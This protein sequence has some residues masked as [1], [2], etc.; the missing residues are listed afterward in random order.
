MAHLLWHASKPRD[1]LLGRIPGHEGLY[2]V[3]RHPD[4]VQIPGLVVYLPQ[5]SLVFFNAEYIMR[6][7]L[8]NARRLRDPGAWLILD[9]SAMNEMDSTGVAAL[10]DARAELVRRGLRFGI[11]DLH[12]R[13][14]AIIERSGLARRIGI[15]MLF[16]S[17]EQAAAAFD[18]QSHAESAHR[19]AWPVGS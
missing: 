8:K 9:A 11:A 5:S 1:A 14:R 10:E 12:S 3:H 17:A 15:D 6:R 4:A 2:K 18:A 16:E 13:P 7:L 19:G